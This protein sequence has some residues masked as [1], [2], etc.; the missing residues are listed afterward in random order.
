[1]GRIETN[2][3]LKT[4]SKKLHEQK[5]NAI[6]L[7]RA[8]GHPVK[9]AKIKEKVAYLEVTNEVYNLSMLS[10]NNWFI[11]TLLA[12]QLEMNS[13]IKMED[14][15]HFLYHDENTTDSIKNK[16]AKLLEAKTNQRLLQDISWFIKYANNHETRINEY[17]LYRDLINWKDNA[18]RWARTIVRKKEIKQ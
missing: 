3:F 6:T 10:S 13:I 9:S 11:V 2:D 18:Y 12:R 16:I 5:R 7:R 8:F 14:Y 1:M 15:L 17:S 4:V